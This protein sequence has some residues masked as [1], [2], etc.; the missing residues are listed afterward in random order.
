[1]T[2]IQRLL[3]VPCLA[4]L[5]AVLLI[6]AVQERRPQKLNLLLWTSPSLPIGGWTA[7]SVLVG[8]GISGATALLLRPTGA[9]L[10]RTERR[11][12]ADG[13]YDDRDS[14]FSIDPRGTGWTSEPRQPMPER[15]IRDPA[16][17]VAVAY[18][19]VQRPQSKGESPPAAAAAAPTRDREVIDQ[20]GDDPDRNW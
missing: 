7:I 12:L 2:R 1:M 17:T 3:L 10:R 4:P 14:A 13:P 15:D 18:R 5:L 8:G 6:S 19:V 11:S 16:P 20:W 9:R